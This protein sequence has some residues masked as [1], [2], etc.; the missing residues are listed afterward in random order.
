M[1]KGWTQTKLEDVLSLEY[2]KSLTEQNRDGK[3][4]PVYGSAG[5]V[6]FHSEPLIQDSPVI[7]VGRKGTA[8]AV[9]LSET[10]CFVIDTAYFVQTKKVINVRFLYLVLL[11]IDL[12]S[13]T[14]QTG[15]PGLNRDR[16][17]GLCFQLPPLH[18]QERIVDLISSVDSYIDALL[19]Q[20]ENARKSRSAV[21]HE[22]LSAGGDGWHRDQL[23]NL[24]K[25]NRGGSPRPIRKYITDDPD[26]INWVKI[27]DA[28]ASTKFIYETKQKILSSGVERSRP[29]KWGDFILSNSMSYGRPYIMRTD[30]AIHDGWLLLSE[31]E[32]NFD[33]D[34]L[35]NLLLSDSVQKQFDSLSAGS[36][37]QNLNIDVVKKVEVR[38]PNVAIQRNISRVLNEFDVF[39]LRAENLILHSRELRSGLLSDLL[40]GEYE[41]PASYDKV[42]AV[43]I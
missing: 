41:I 38:I 15:V 11:E 1:R 36:G 12:K 30:G 16:A 26:G 6:G 31:V 42:M 20:A 32:K 7:I 14:A 8:G 22:M 5:V 28:T 27:A 29:V 4:F 13:V 37:V 39:L 43:A 19:H 18:E 17:Y 2:G 25:I 21:L 33:E 10:P 35:Y 9:Y 23:G 24:L 40:S 34:F 3:G